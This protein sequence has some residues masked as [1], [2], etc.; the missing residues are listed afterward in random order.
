M[1][2]S[3][4]SRLQDIFKKLKGVGRLSEAQIEKALKE[5]RL[6]LLE[7]DVNYK[8]VKKFIG[9]VSEKAKGKEVLESLT[10]AQQ[11]IKI[12]NNE[13]IAALGG[14][15]VALR[16]FSNLDK[17]RLNPI[18]I[19]GLNGSG[20]T[21]SCAKLAS[22]YKKQG[23]APLVIAADMQRPAAVLQ[24]KQLGER[25]G[26]EVFSAE[27]KKPEEVVADGLAYAYKKGSN[28]TLIDTAGRLHVDSELMDELVRIRALASPAEI[29]LVLDAMT[30]Q[31]SVNIAS[32]FK[33]YLD[34]S[35]VV[36]SKYDGD[37]R[38]GATLSIKYIT[39]LDIL[40]VGTGEKPENLEYFY[41]DRVASR[42]L[43]M[44]DV[45][46]LIE[47]AQE[48]FDSKKAMELERK[49]QKE[50]FTF[51]D[52]LEQIKSIKNMG[53]LEQVMEMIPGIGSL[54]KKGLDL[55]GSENEF[56]K[57]EAIIN[58]M[59][60]K[61]RLAPSLINGSRKI[62]IAKGSGTTVNDV[63][64]LLNQFKQAKG[65]M[66]KMSKFSKMFSLGKDSFS[67]FIQ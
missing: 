8:V 4:S 54:R 58:S 5:I 27:G 28:L 20:K 36:F 38:G 3:L 12:V 56:K 37:S 63:N 10:P 2:D 32:T 41:P 59:T 52:F 13:L 29:F 46:S 47:K 65:M 64:K 23:Y 17:T 22:Y 11:V 48:A 62:R 51:E 14:A 9:D 55:A 53:S 34:I 42:I 21:T 19:V 60:R 18:M 45:L 43:G 57:V 7:A 40:F 26:V 24:L 35:G 31:E 33:E 1:F 25:I 39:G 67:P 66:R 61:E 49:L 6:A 30:G 50:D 44:G 16:G 15:R